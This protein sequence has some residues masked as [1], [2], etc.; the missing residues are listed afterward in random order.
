MARKYWPFIAGLMVFVIES[1]GPPTALVWMGLQFFKSVETSRTTVAP[2]ESPDNVVC[3]LPPLTEEPP[4]LG[5]GG[6]GLK[7][8]VSVIGPFSVTDTELLLP[9]YE[10]EPVP[11]QLLKLKPLFAVALIATTVPLSYHPLLEFTPPPA[12]APTARS[13]C[14]VKFAV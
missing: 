7:L 13:Y 1:V 14:V 4:K 11:A 12:P 10:P 6:F 8:A 3:N 2:D 9:E 5:G